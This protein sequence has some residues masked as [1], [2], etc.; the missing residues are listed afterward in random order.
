MDSGRFG[1]PQPWSIRWRGRILL[2]LA[3]LLLPTYWR[4]YLAAVALPSLLVTLVAA[5][6][7]PE[8]P[9]WLVAQV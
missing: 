4:L 2:P 8:S 6:R 5:A 7:L 1:F 9:R 3:A